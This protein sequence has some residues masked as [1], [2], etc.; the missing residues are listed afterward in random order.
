MEL[1]I[2][3]KHLNNKKISYNIEKIIDRIH[4]S[5]ENINNLKQKRLELSK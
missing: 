1:K 5:K 2:G 3:L 4:F